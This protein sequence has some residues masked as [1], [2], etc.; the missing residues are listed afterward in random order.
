MQWQGRGNE[1][2]LAFLGTF[3]H[4]FDLLYKRA[5]SQYASYREEATQLLQTG[6]QN[7][8]MGWTEPRVVPSFFT[9]VPM[10]GMGRKE[11]MALK[12]SVSLVYSHIIDA[13]MKSE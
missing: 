7:S 4:G 5:C 8:G 2:Y 10:C 6:E 12:N 9:L 1:S 11:R 13:V 3:H